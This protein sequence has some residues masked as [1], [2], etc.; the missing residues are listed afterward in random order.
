MKAT[1]YNLTNM[2]V[3]LDG[4]N[5]T[6]APQPLECS[7]PL[8]AAVV[9]RYFLV[10]ACLAPAAYARADI[11]WS[12]SIPNC[13]QCAPVPSKRSWFSKLGNRQAKPPVLHVIE[14]YTPEDGRQGIGVEFFRQQ[15]LQ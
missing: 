5:L 15:Y 9:E 1:L 7:D 2:P 6:M 13:S 14:H 4:Q 12:A 3:T 8:P 10:P 11:V